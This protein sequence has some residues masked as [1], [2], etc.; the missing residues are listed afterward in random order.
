[1]NK[2]MS[3]TE[4]NS[5]ISEFAAQNTKSGLIGG[6]CEDGFPIYYANAEMAEMFGYGSVDE[7]AAAID[8]KVANT[9][10][11]DDMP[12]VEKDLGGS[13]YEGMTYETTYRMP[14]KDGSWFWTVDKGKVIRAEDGR[15]AII[16]SCT[17]MSDF[18]KR[19][20][21]LETRNSVSEYMFRNLPGGY[22]RCKI[23][24][25]FTF[26]YMGER[27][28]NILGWTEEEIR[29]KFDN[30]YVNLV[31][32]DDREI[33]NKYTDHILNGRDGSDSVYEDAIYRLQ[34]KD[35]YHWVSDTSVKL[36]VSGFTFVQC[37]ISEISSI[38]T[39]KE[40]REKE[41]QRSLAASELRYE[42]ISALGVAYKRDMHRRPY[43]DA[44][45]SYLWHSGGQ[46]RLT[47][48][49]LR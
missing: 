32:P 36:T 9:I 43:K 17:D 26:L 4:K 1:M 45:Y 40:N 44:V 7:L 29:T 46:E 5:L 21:E 31:C 25:D 49:P 30:K 13:Y 37:I 27:F 11:P 15:L 10:H 35:G 23:D 6:Y 48:E 42:I 22:V 33:L 8:G 34:G 38:M 18:V 19:Q 47:G 2:F 14:R 39:E 41:M 16:S 20:K 24:E 12:Q 3:Q 28:L